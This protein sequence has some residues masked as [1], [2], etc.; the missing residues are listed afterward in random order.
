MEFTKE[1]VPASVGTSQRTG[2]FS[3]SANEINAFEGFTYVC[4]SKLEE[5]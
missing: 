3:T 1:V 2:G 4:P 5:G